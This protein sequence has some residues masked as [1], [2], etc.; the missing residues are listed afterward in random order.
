MIATNTSSTPLHQHK[1]VRQFVKFIIVGLSSFLVNVGS[2]YVLYYMLHAPYVPALTLA[3]VISVCNG[4]VWNRRW[5]FKE[6][7]HQAAH[8]QY[9][10]FMLVNI[11]GY[12]LNTTIA[13]LVIAHFTKVAGGAHDLLTVA[14]QIVLGTAKTVYPKKLVYGASFLAAS[15]VVFWNFFANRYWT[16]KHPETRDDDPDDSV[17]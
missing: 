4:F 9:M 2:L 14:G 8:D 7:R 15:V 3:F 12:I 1:G 6:S 10:R 17:D 11:V 16:F 5:T 13:V